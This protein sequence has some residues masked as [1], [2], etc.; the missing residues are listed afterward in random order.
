M[1]SD[2]LDSLLLN[3]DKKNEIFNKVKVDVVKLCSRYPI[4]QGA[5]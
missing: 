3:D 5:Y 4:Y 1:I 2:I